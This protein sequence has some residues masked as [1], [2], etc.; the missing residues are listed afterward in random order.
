[1][2]GFHSAAVQFHSARHHSKRWADVKGSTRN[3]RRD[4]N[5]LQPVAFV[6]FEKIQRPLMKMLPV[7]GWRAM[8]QLVVRVH[9]LRCGG[10]LDDWSVKC[11]LSLVFL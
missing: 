10:R 2:T 8:K 1:M 7:P 11:V 9:F 5:V 6:W 4:Q 3:G